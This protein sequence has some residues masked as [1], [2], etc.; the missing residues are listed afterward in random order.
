MTV[1]EFI[2]RKN[3][4]LEDITDIRLVPDDQIIDVEPRYLKLKGLTEQSKNDGLICP[5]C[6]L[7]ADDDCHGCVM[8]D[9]DNECNRSGDATYDMIKENL[10]EKD[11]GY[12]YEIPAIVQLVA[13]Y[14]K[15]FTK[16]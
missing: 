7:Y 3:A 4:I 5:Y 6:I 13:E 1:I 16:G 14:N 9:K 8:R 11:I 12:I 2:Q 10:N 15:Q